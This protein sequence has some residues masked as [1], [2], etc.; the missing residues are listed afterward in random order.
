MK[1][2]ILIDDEEAGI[3]TMKLLLAKHAPN[4]KVVASTTS[5][6]EGLELIHDYRPDVIFLDISMPTMNGFELLDRI[7]SK[8]YKIIF[9]TAHEEYALK[10]LKVKAFDYL[11]K[12]I[13][14][15][16]LIN[17]LASLEASFSIKNSPNTDF[18]KG[19]TLIELQVK[20]GIIFIK[21]QE[22][23]HLKASGNYTEFYLQNGI[24][25]LV[26]RSIKEYASQLDTTLF[27]RCH[28]SHV[29]NLNKV[30]RLLNQDGYFAKMH[31]GTLIEVSKK[32]KDELLQRMK[33]L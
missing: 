23:V 1:R 13:D 16:D 10:A 7:D 32:N 18:N 29:I 6:E 22:I 4:L 25:H 26:S 30:E 15:D 20:D 12:P 5:P 8:R 19:P 2:A 9:T 31:D 27:F 11:L 28:H 3:T 21:Q 17:C 14:V 24:K 33:N